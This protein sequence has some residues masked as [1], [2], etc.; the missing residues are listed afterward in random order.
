MQLRE[1]KAACHK[2]VFF[3]PRALTREYTQA[4]GTQRALRETNVERRA[5]TQDAQQ[6]AA[7]TQRARETNVENAELRAQKTQRPVETASSIFAG[8]Q[9]QERAILPEASGG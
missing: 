6:Q 2:Q 1:V 5:K 9:L 7:G 4:A 3:V 8:L